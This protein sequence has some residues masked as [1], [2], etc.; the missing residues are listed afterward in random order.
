MRMNVRQFRQHD[1]ARELDW[2][3]SELARKRDGRSRRRR[4]VATDE[5][6]TRAIESVITARINLI[7]VTGV[8]RREA[9]M[10]DAGAANM[11]KENLESGCYVLRLARAGKVAV[12]CFCE[13]LQQRAVRVTAQPESKNT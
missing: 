12:T 9:W 10:L 5:R 13:F 4:T 3:S 2:F 1:I 11:V 8:V 6:E 7:E